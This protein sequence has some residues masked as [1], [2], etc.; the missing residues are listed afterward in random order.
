LADPK[1]T[2][3]R[4]D[5]EQVHIRP[6]PPR[7][8]DRLGGDVPNR[9]EDRQGIGEHGEEGWMSLSRQT[10]VQHRCEAA[11]ADMDRKAR[12]DQH[13]AGDRQRRLDAAPTLLGLRTGTLLAVF[14][15][16][17]AHTGALDRLQYCGMMLG[18][19]STC[20]RHAAIDKIKRQV[21]QP[22]NRPD[23]ALENRDFVTAVHAVDLED[24]TVRTVG[25]HLFDRRRFARAAAATARLCFI[26]GERIRG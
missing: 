16:F 18:V 4:D 15:E 19:S 12:R 3:H 6:E 25:K 23:F 1:G 26:F 22:N 24:D 13:A 2:R 14:P 17:D 20:D 9:R 21:P 11:R 5:H 10:L 8:E 7:R